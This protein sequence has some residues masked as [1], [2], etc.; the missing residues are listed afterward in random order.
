MLDPISFVVIILAK[1]F[2]NG[3]GNEAG[4][5]AYYALRSALGWRYPTVIPNLEQLELNPSSRELQE[6]LSAALR[7]LNAENDKDLHRLAQQLR[8]TIEFGAPLD[9]VQQLKRSAG[10]RQLWEI[11]QEHLERIRFIQANYSIDSSY[12]LSSSIYRATQVPDYIRAEVRSLHGRIRQ[13]IEHIANL[14]E[15]GQYGNAEDYVRR[16]PARILQERAAVLV[17]A[18]KQLHV[19]FQTLRLTV[20]FF[21]KFNEAV[22]SVIEQE[23]SAENQMQMMFGN[24]IM[25]YELTDFVIGFVENFTPGGL[26]DLEELHRQAQQ[27]VETIRADQQRLSESV[28]QDG[29]DQRVRKGILADVQNREKALKSYEEEW[30][31]YIAEVQQFYGPVDEVRGQILSLQLIRENARVQIR[32]LQ[33]VAMLRF[34]KQ[35]TDSIRASVDVLASFQL[36]PLDGERVRR[37][38]NPQE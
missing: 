36:A 25:L 35:N 18:D 7:K 14:I 24:A 17:R 26:H 21:G 3:M 33:Q 9:P 30:Q 6:K 29:I 31:R 37:L 34:L 2:L 32:V 8:E 28:D 38:V 4:K 1:G 20:E 23:A 12:L 16:L 15:G 11:F 22:L 5:N 10:F 19:S 13:L 27:H